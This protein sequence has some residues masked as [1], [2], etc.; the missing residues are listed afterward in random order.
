M[1]DY[2]DESEVT[3]I[4]RKT[5]TETRSESSYREERDTRS[6]RDDL[7]NDC[8]VCLQSLEATNYSFIKVK[9]LSRFMRME[10]K[11][12]QYEETN[13][14]SHSVC[15]ACG[16]QDKGGYSSTMRDEQGER[17]SR[18]DNQGY[19][20]QEQRDMTDG[21]SKTRSD[22][23]YEEYQ[24]GEGSTSM[25]ERGHDEFIREGEGYS[26]TK[27]EDWSY[28]KTTRETSEYVSSTSHEWERDVVIESESSTEV[29]EGAHFTLRIDGDE[30][31]LLYCR[32]SGQ[33]ACALQKLASIIEAHRKATTSRTQAED[34]QA[35]S[36]EMDENAEIV[37]EDGEG[38]AGTSDVIGPQRCDVSVQTDGT[39]L[40]ADFE[41]FS[42]KDFEIYYD[43]QK[44]PWFV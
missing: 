29:P 37:G 7:K 14:T 38:E 23:G 32:R 12:T 20:V 1:D 44:S 39:L 42:D 4:T 16:R 30:K 33:H 3:R 5:T 2:F 24:S 34:V 22:V 21:Y 26:S 41:V 19:A 25:Y 35:Q 15:F 36:S 10:E 31:C 18:R 8:P 43:E 11:H 17:G 27:R 6:S 13:E 9:D 28:E 40:P